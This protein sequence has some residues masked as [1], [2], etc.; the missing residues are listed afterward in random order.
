[1]T[2]A[3]RGFAADDKSVSIYVFGD[4]FTGGSIEEVLDAVDRINRKDAQGRPRVRVHAVGFPT[5]FTTRGV[6]E[7]TGVRF[8]TL[9]RLLCQENGGTFVGL[10]EVRP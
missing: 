1:V 10:T 7:Y 4:E 5:V 2:R 6:S 8:A 3:V 9:M